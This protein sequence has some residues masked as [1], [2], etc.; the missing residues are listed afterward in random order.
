MAGSKRTTVIFPENLFRNL[1]FY[2]VNNNV[3]MGEVI[4]EATREFLKKKGYQPD[5]ELKGIKPVY[6]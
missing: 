4:R 2:S 1:K 6:E 5:K 3:E